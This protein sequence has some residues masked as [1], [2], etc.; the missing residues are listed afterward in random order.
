MPGSGTKDTI[1]AM[2]TPGEFVV[3]KEATR[4]YRNELEFMNAGGGVRRQELGGE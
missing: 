4:R 3:N 2:L 1:P